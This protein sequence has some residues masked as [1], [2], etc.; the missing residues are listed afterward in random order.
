M[1]KTILL[2][3]ILIK[4]LNTLSVFKWHDVDDDDDD[5]VEIFNNKFYN[6]E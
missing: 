4:F 1:S 3:Y 5:A 2:Y 6:H